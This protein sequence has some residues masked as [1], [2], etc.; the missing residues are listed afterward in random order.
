MKMDCF[1]DMPCNLK[2]AYAL[3]AVLFVFSVFNLS[4]IE[5]NVSEGSISDDYIETWIN[6]NPEVILESVNRFAV[7]QQEEMVRQQRAQSAENIK[8]FDKELKD[9]KYAGVL[10]PK[11]TIEIIEFYDYNCGYC[12]MAAR[13]IKQLLKNRKDAKV[14]LRNIPILGQPSRY[15]AEVGMAIL[16]E[17]PAK[18]PEFHE[19]LMNGSARSKE[20]V[21]KAISSIGL[22]PSKIEEV[23][24]K[25]KKEI[26]AAIQSNMELANKIGINGT[27][28]FIINGELIPGAVDA[29]TL[30]NMLK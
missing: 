6:E 5:K 8:N 9:T 24:K 22:K 25:N 20:E 15:A 12:K 4:K 18:Y 2:F 21:N 27:P 14:I 30:E 29:Q 10:N 1:K 19:A 28:A 23:L 16:I 3:I 11:G 7:Q 13:N 26:D 17:D